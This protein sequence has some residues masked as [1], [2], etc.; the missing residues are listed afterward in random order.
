MKKLHVISPNAIARS[1]LVKEILA[2]ISILI[3]YYRNKL[4][5]ILEH[6]C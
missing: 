2:E 5:T 6:M 1:P 4:P 3:F